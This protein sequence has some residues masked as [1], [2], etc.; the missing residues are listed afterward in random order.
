MSLLV[1]KTTGG[2]S[3]DVLKSHYAG[4]L[5]RGIGPHVVLFFKTITSR[6]FFAF[7]FAVLAVCGLAGAIPWFLLV[8]AGMWLTFIICSAPMVLLLSARWNAQSLPAAPVAP[9]TPSDQ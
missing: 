3:F 2:G 5:S 8:G 9:A 7:L 6:D 4:R 1:A